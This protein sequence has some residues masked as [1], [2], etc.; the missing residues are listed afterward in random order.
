MQASES[1]CERAF[2]LRSTSHRAAFDPR[3]DPQFPIS[4]LTQNVRT[5]QTHQSRLSVSQRESLPEGSSFV[6]SM[7]PSPVSTVALSV[8][9]VCS[10]PEIRASSASNRSRPPIAAA[11]VSPDAVR[12]ERLER[13]LL[14]AW[15]GRRG[16]GG[17]E[18]SRCG[19]C[20][21]ARHAERHTDGTPPRCT[22][23]SAP[24]RTRIEW[25]PVF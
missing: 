4:T 16:G 5:H 11:A 14:L 9:L 24:R 23:G 6:G 15:G 13:R 19:R 22:Q 20:W 8:T 1:D 2:E 17:G 12:R 18:G 10:F 7:R 25:T 21:Y 3:C